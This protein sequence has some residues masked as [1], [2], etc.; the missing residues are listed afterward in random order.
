MDFYC[1][2]H[3][4]IL[5][6]ERLAKK[7]LKDGSCVLEPFAGFQNIAKAMPQYKWT[8]ND[9]QNLEGLDFVGD[10][11]SIPKKKFD[12]IITNPPFKNCNTQ[13][14]YLLSMLMEYSDLLILVLPATMMKVTNLQEIANW[15]YVVKENESSCNWFYRPNNK[16]KKKVRCR[17]MVLK[18]T[19]IEDIPPVILSCPDITFTDELEYTDVIIK[20]RS[21]CGLFITKKD[22]H[23]MD[24]K[25]FAYIA[26]LRN[27][28]FYMKHITEICENIY[29]YT[30][31]YSLHISHIKNNEISHFFELCRKRRLHEDAKHQSG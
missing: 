23:E 22:D 2:S 16:D 27:K 10:Y 9:I 28:D 17:L 30:R 18:K 24:P 25:Y 19:P 6:L 3:E 14:L 12:A 8:T 26:F 13:L 11:R 20:K 21:F 31:K 5:C 1:T 7:Y 29:Y 15:G 4:D